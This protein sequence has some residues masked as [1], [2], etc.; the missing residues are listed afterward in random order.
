MRRLK[1]EFIHG[2]HI[3]DVQVGPLLRAAEDRDLLHAP[4]ASDTARKTY[5]NGYSVGRLRERCTKSASLDRHHDV[6][7]G[8][9]A[10]FNALARGEPR[11][12][13]AALGGLFSPTNLSDLAGARIANRRF[14][15]AIFS[16][17]CLATPIP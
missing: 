12:G 1:H 11:L 16:F 17:A 10:L 15:K 4:G 8:L 9:R 5:R 7:G 14:L 3:L 13:L 2:A 6:W